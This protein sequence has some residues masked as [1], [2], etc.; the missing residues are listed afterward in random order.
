LFR[1]DGKVAVVT[2]GTRGI[3]RAI[4]LAL[5]EAGAKLVVNYLSNEV[6]AEETAKLVG[7]FNCEIAFVKG[8]IGKTETAQRIVDEAI[9][10]FGQIDI[11]VNNAGKT[12][13]NLLIRMSDEEWDTVIETNLR[14][15]F[16]MTRAALRPMIRA[17]KGRIITITS[18]DGLVGNAGQANYSAAKAGQIG[19]TKS[20]AREV[21]SRGITVNAVAPGIVKTMM[22]EVLNDSQWGKI[23]DRIPMNRDGKPEE[24]APVVVFLAS[25]EA[26]YITGQVIAIDGGLTT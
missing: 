17:R 12:A 1:L 18:V 4:T 20:M 24:I 11:L 5:A 14:S 6:T 3:G 22:T 10:R 9:A 2:G 8:D 13:D 16:L 15:T 25:E 19:F 23:L 7:E 21:A 26:S